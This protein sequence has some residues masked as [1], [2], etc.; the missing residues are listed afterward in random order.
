MGV[1]AVSQ[2]R[3]IPLSSTVKPARME[4]R[5]AHRVVPPENSNYEG[6]VVFPFFNPRAA[7]LFLGLVIGLSLALA[8]H[9]VY[10]TVY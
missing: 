7:N 5:L 2:R 9:W 8:C 1:V 4:S 3:R 6:V 10:W